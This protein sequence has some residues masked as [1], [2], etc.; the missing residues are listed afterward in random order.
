MEEVSSYLD[1]Q[2]TAPAMGVKQDVSEEQM[3]RMI[4]LLYADF[5]I[6][7]GGKIFLY[8]LDGMR[9]HYGFCRKAITRTNLCV[10]QI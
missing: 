8:G 5:G 9:I 4:D 2:I 3:T 6:F 10:L 1:M 7:A